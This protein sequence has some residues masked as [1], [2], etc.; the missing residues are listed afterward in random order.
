MLELSK[1]GQ[2]DDD[3]FAS[4]F[5][6][7]DGVTGVFEISVQQHLWLYQVFITIISD[8]T[9]DLVRPVSRVHKKVFEHS[10]FFH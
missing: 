10:V 7:A 6:S 4:V 1:L 5:N 8:R 9:D 2:N 3:I